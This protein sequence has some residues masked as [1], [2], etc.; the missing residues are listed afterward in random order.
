M[1]STYPAVVE[2]DSPRSVT[3]PAANFDR[4]ARSYRWAEYLA[5]GPLLRLTREHFLS[6]LTGTRHALVLGDGDGRFAAQLLRR[7]PECR[8]V[9]VDSSAAMLALLRARC[10]RTGGLFRTTPKQTSVLAMH[11]GSDC[12]LIATH[13]LL[14]CLTQD[15]VNALALRLA[16]DVKPR[17]RWVISE[18]CKPR[19][20]VAGFFG[21]AYIRLLY[22]AFRALT[23]LHV[24]GLPDPGQ[25]LHAAGFV[26][27]ERRER[28]LGL[29]YSELW[30]LR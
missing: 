4:V 7:A 17:C 16:A 1:R 29:L 14:D 20:R 26:K 19:G 6:Q 23:G 22:F 10:A 27:L 9:A 11:A 25:A 8:I 21:A 18:F 13:F 2:E 12:D 5:L 24:H 28:L 15:E 30:Q 3:Q